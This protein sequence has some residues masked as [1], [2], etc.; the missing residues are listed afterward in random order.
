MDRR[1]RV[2]AAPVR[3]RRRRC[4]PRWSRSSSAAPRDGAAGADPRAS[5]PRGTKA[6][7]GDGV[8]R[9]SRRRPGS[10]GS[11][12]EQ[13]E[14]ITGLTAALPRALRLPVHRLRA[15]AHAG[16]DHRR[17][18]GARRRRRP[19][20]RSDR[21]GRDRQDRPAAPRRPGGGPDDPDQLRQARGARALRRRP[22]AARA[23]GDPGVA[24]SARS[25]AGLLA[26]EV[27]MEVL[28]QGF[29]AAY[30]E[31][32]N[33][34]VVATD[35]MKNVILRHALE[36]DGPVAGGVPRL[37]RAGASS[38]PTRRWRA[39]RLRARELPFAPRRRGERSDRLFSLGGGEHGVAELE[40]E[41]GDGASARPRAAG[42][43][44]CG[45]SRRPAR[46]SRGSRATTR[47]RCPSAP[48][49]RCSSTWTCT[50]ATR[51]PGGRARRR[52]GA[53][54]RGRAGA[55][56]RSAPSSTSSCRESIQHLVHEMGQR[57]LDRFPALDEVVV[58][59]PRT[60]RTTRCPGCEPGADRRAY[61]AA[62]PAWGLIT[63]TLS[64]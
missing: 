31:G 2:G 64:R 20:R 19:T 17:R 13:Y 55:R 4:T 24:A 15:R 39:L 47:R 14:R 46:R 1:S 59:A 48:T 30:T 3:E 38:A 23:A 62:F 12:R 37:A 29:L 63:L 6:R 10:T 51:D 58:R 26:C 49:G 25:T 54:R 57:L 52:P 56:R 18:R 44:A 36:H 50:G 11:R 40:L 7:I 28:G 43:S 61:T 45:C 5:R 53:L 8:R 16:H 27:S 60:T 42:W 35:T 9:A 21:A 33:R 22:A 32:D 34:D 41:R